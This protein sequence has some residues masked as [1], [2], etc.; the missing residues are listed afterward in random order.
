MACYEGDGIADRSVKRRI[1]PWDRDEQVHRSLVFY[2]RHLVAHPLRQFLALVS[3]DVSF[4]SHQQCP[5]EMS[6]L[7][8]AAKADTDGCRASIGMQCIGPVEGFHDF[9]VQTKTFAILPP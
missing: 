4:G 5:W 2:P 6:Q 8:I 1:L 3:Q 9:S 7:G